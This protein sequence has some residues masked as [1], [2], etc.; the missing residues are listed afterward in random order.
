MEPVDTKRIERLIADLDD[1]RFQVREQATR[2]L[3]ALAERAAPA[4]RKAQAG[5]P[6]LEM[7]RRLDALLDRLDGTSPSTETVR[8]IRAVEALEFIGNA[9]AR[10]LLDK[11]AAGPAE[12]RLAQEAKAAT[13]RLTKRASIP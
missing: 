5:K 12:T 4:L 2:E 7:R 13:V 1:E 8:Q 11:L 10:R 6:T 9:E 3:Q